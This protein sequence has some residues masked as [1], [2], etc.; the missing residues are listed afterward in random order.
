VRLDETIPMRDFVLLSLVI[1]CID[2][3]MYRECFAVRP[4]E[5]ILMSDFVLPFNFDIDNCTETS[6]SESI[7]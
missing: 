1:Y 6:P 4:D 5:I 3:V 2:I 7:P